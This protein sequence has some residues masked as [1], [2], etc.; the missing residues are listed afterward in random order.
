MSLRL[1]AFAALAFSLPLAAEPIVFTLDPAQTQVHFTLGTLL[2][3]VHGSFQLEKGTVSFD[4]ASGQALGEVIVNAATGDSGNTSRDSRMHKSI[5]ESAKFPRIVFRPDRID[6]QLPDHGSSTLQVHGTLSIHGADHEL[7]VPVELQT[8]PDQP[9]AV[10][11]FTI[12]YVQ[13]GMKNPSTLFL[14]VND[15]VDIEIQAAGRFSPP[16]S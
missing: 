4:P 3:T 13:W 8:G 16:R 2:H 15:K 10:L 11:R 6:G 1:F 14:R 5:L 12:P 9:S 7:T